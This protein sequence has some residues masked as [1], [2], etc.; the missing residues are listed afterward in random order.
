MTPE[1]FQAAQATLAQ[2][3]TELAAL[4]QTINDCIAQARAFNDKGRETRNARTALIAKVQPLRDECQAFSIA[5]KAEQAAK[6]KAQAEANLK[7]ARER[8]AAEAAAKAKEQSE[9]EK[10]RAELA[11]LKAAKG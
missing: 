5:A 7:A 6:A 2:V 3:D 8:E 11:E 4:D 10:L 1:Q 9:I